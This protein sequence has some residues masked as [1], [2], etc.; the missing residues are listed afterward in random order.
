MS[1]YINLL[2]EDE[3]HFH[4]AAKN[5]R[6]LKGGLIALGVALL[7]GIHLAVKDYR[8][9][10]K[11]AATLTKTW[12]TMEGEVAKAKTRLD[13]LTRLEREE[14]TLSGWSAS[15]RDWRDLLTFLQRR[16]PAP[17]EQFQFRR[18]LVDENMV[19]LRTL[20]PGVDGYTYPLRREARME[21][22]GYVQGERVEPVIADYEARLRDAED[23]KS[24][25]RSVRLDNIANLG[26]A[27]GA[28]VAAPPNTKEFDFTLDLHS[29]PLTP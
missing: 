28:A 4:S 5:S 6:L 16:M 23:G 10:M 21:L 26:P 3:R 18:L 2:E 20:N 29:R 7:L 15:R 27:I 25:I 1:H 17:A 19:G 8:D 14:K 11:Q 24:P 9:T 22:K 13:Q 12:Q